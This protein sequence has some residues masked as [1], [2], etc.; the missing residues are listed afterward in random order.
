MLAWTGAGHSYGPKTAVEGITLSVAAG[1]V[2][3]LVGPS[4]CGKTTLLHMAGGLLEPSE[5]SVGNGFRRTAFVFQEPRL[6]PWRR[7]GDNIT[8]GLKASGAG[9]GQ[10]RTVAEAM[11]RRMGLDG[12]DLDKFPHELSGGMR[13]RIALARALA[14]EPDLLLLDEPFS[15]LDVGL[16]RELQ[17]LLVREIEGRGLAAVFITHDLAEAVRLSDDIAVLAPA[18]GRLVRSLRL[19]RPRGA[20]DDGFIY[21]TVAALLRDPTVADAFRAVRE[22]Q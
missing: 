19:D 12:G 18:P 14:V 5:G 2:L 17:D 13:Q 15:A 7:A 6:L 10:R 8:F 4:G 9:A 22:D 21:E 3:S 16:R 20:R 1:Q 11:A